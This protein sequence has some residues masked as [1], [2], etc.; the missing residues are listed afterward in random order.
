VTGLLL[1]ARPSAAE[2]VFAK[3]ERHGWEFLPWGVLAGALIAWGAALPTL[4]GAAVSQFGLLASGSPLLLVSIL[5][6]VVGFLAA[7]RRG[8][9]RAAAAAVVAMV[10][11]QRATVPLATAVPLYSWTYKHLGVVDYI[12]RHGHVARGVDIY[13]GWPG[14]FAATAWFSKLSGV[15]PITIAHWFTPAVHLLLAGLIAV[16]ARS[17]GASALVGVAAAFIV[18]SLNWVGQDYYSPQATALVLAVAM[19]VVVGLAQ[20]RP[21]GAWLI[22]LLFSAITVSHQLTPYWLILATTLLSVARRL[23]PRWLPAVLAAIAGCYLALNWNVA[24]HFPLLSF[25]PVANAQSNIATTG[26]FGQIVTSDVVRALSVFLWSIAALA[27]VVD[28]RRKRP[29]LTRAILAFSAFLILGGQGYGGEAIFRVFLYALPGCALLVAPLLVAAAQA[30]LAVRGLAWVAAAAAVT[31]SAQGYFGG[32]FANRMTP[33][34]VRFSQQ[35]LA[36]AAFPSYLTVAAPVWPE[37]PTGR[38]VAFARFKAGYDYPMVYAA[39][40]VGARFDNSKDYAAFTHLIADRKGGPTYLIIS[41]QM[42]IYDWYFGILPLG[43]LENLRSQMLHDPR[44]KVVF[45]TTQ[46]IVFETTATPGTASP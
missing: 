6:V 17:W 1:G 20:R 9:I 27:A 13:N 28:W 12:G 46:F 41:R 42:E 3:R 11:V 31:A 33:D 44:W 8:Q 38:Y 7:V 24:S 45:S 29:V 30:K 5:L 18:E 37:R 36:R 35:L 26:V 4:S 22:V 23:R 2:K 32:W 39:K 40:L 43:A 16:L 14:L 19:L 25:N 34:Q 10:I 15:A 21:V